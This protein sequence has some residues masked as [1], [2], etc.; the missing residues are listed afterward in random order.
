MTEELHIG[1]DGTIL[2][3]TILED[4]VPAPISD[5]TTK[6][7]KFEK[8]DGTTFSKTADFLTDGSDGKLKYVTAEADFDTAGVWRVQAFVEL[9]DWYGN[10]S[11]ATLRVYPNIVITI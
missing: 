1:D 4:N 10:S 8:P 3:F 7:I 9:S 11:I 6:T 2:V 5:A